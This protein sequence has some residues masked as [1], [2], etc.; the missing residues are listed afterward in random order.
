MDAPVVY[1]TAHADQETIGRAKV[2]EPL[3]YVLKPISSSDLRSVVE[4]SLYRH[5]MERRGEPAKPGS[6]P[7]F[8]VWETALSPP[9]PQAK[10]SS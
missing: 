4:I 3:G 9:M 7:R 5:Q 10:S 8:A 1:M 2:T 6:P